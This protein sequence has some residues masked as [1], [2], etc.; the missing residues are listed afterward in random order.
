M[1]PATDGPWPMLGMGP[2][3]PQTPFN[4]A[5]SPHTC[6]TTTASPPTDPSLPWGPPQVLPISGLLFPPPCPLLSPARKGPSSTG[7]PSA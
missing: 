6:S 7:L 1:D 5:F 2:R 4:L 3:S